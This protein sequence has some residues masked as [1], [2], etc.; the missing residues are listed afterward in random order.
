MADRHV[1]QI[2]IAR[3]R[4]D[5]DDPANADFMAALDAVNA[6]ADG[7]P[8]FVWRLVGDGNDATDVEVVPDDPNLIVNMS[9][10][11]DVASLE[12]FAYRHAGHRAVLV[13]RKEWFEPLEPSYA[14]WWVEVDHLPTV[15]EGLAALDE[16]G[17]KGPRERVFNFRTA[18]R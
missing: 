6:A 5:K 7:S 4:A 10:W 3:F 1:A 12:A 9:V 18:N 8:G 16:L 14:L 11:R 2:N 15:A 13:R 17:R